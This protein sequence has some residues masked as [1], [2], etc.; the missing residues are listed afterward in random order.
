MAKVWQKE[1][2]GKLDPVIESYE[3]GQD[4][5]LDGKLFKYELAA[6]QAHSLMLN[7][8]GILSDEEALKVNKEIRSL[9]KKYGNE[10]RQD[11]AEGV[12]LGVEG[13]PTYVVNGNVIPGGIS[14]EMW[15][16][17]IGY[18]LKGEL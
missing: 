10:I 16:E 12:D 8:I 3:V 1:D 17:I 6:S 13:T 7:K 4:Y 18:I 9:Y 11:K 15:E 14:Y 5:I 2:S